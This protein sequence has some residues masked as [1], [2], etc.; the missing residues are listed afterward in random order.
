MKIKLSLA[1]IL[2]V[3]LVGC[4]S[5]TPTMT[6][7]PAAI[8]VASTPEEHQRIA[9]FYTQKAIEYDATAVAHEK[10]AKAYISHPK[11]NPGSLTAHCRALQDQFAAAAKEARALAQMH[12]QMAAG[13]GY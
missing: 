9:N 6:D 12:S 13:G 2:F 7:I 8:A 11:G 3:S 10:N 4:A 1:G 5:V